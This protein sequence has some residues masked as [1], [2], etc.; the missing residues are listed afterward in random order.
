MKIGHRT[1]NFN[2]P[3]RRVSALETPTSRVGRSPRCRR[4]GGAPIDPL[5]SVRARAVRA[6]RAGQG[7]MLRIASASRSWGRAGTLTALAWHACRSTWRRARAP[8]YCD[9]GASTPPV[10]SHPQIS[11][12]PRPTV[13]RSPL[14]AGASGATGHCLIMPAG[15][16]CTQ[17]QQAGC[18]ERPDAPLSTPP[19]H[20]RPAARYAC[21]TQ[22]YMRSACAL[23]FVHAHAAASQSWRHDDA[24]GL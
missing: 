2:P 18:W 7:A 20:W 21:A 3:E 5:R 17:V 11:P 9:G 14:H 15:R 1:S 22:P 6:G 8:H 16:R 4:H 10:R 12:A 23:R 24:R 13:E 19:W